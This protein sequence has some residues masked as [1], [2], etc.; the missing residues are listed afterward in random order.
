M[1]GQTGT[2][3]GTGWQHPSNGF[4]GMVFVFT[5]AAG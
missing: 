2:H 4:Y 1:G 3:M 5:T